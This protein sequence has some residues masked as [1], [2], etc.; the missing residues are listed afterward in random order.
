MLTR[1]PGNKEQ[2]LNVPVS[3]FNSEIPSHSYSDKQVQAIFDGVP[4]EAENDK[5]RPCVSKL[6]LLSNTADEIVYA[7]AASLNQNLAPESTCC[8]E[9]R[10][11]PF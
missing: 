1:T 7:L 8:S 2:V 5:L 3:S 10:G 6:E 9:Y 11:R 4:S